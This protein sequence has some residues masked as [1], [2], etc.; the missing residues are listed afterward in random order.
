M[1]A[2]Y[3]ITCFMLIYLNT[4]TDQLQQWNLSCSDIHYN[5]HPRLVDTLL[6]CENDK[7]RSL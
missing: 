5:V 3:C 2:L 1:T 7:K 4:C 6:G